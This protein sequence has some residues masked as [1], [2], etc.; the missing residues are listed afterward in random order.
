MQANGGSDVQHIQQEVNLTERIEQKIA[1]TKADNL[2]KEASHKNRECSEQESDAQ[3]SFKTSE[4][5]VV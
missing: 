2:N 3:V 1:V 4:H 5:N